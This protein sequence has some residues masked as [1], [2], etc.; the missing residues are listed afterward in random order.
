[1]H[2]N[3]RNPCLFDNVMLTRELILVILSF[4]IISMSALS[5]RR[6]AVIGGGPAGLVTTKQLIDAGIRPKLFTKTIGGMWNKQA[7]PFWPSMKT[8]L[9]KYTCQFSDQSWQK[10]APIFP[11]QADLDSYLNTYAERTLHRANVVLNC[12]ITAVNREL[13]GEY[14]LT[15]QDCSSNAI[16]CE[17]FD[18]VIITTG[19]FCKPILQPVD[20]F[21]GRVIHSSEYRNPEDFAGRNVVVAGSSFSSSEIA[22]DVATV[23]SSVRNVVPRPS[24]M[25]PRFLPVSTDKPNTPFL[26][27]DLLFYQLNPKKDTIEARREVLIKHDADRVKSDTY[28]KCLQ[29]SVA[30]DVMKQVNTTYTTRCSAYF[31]FY[32]KSVLLFASQR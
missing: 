5:I 26:P 18:D 22:A 28:M 14:K 17:T 24:W 6:V 1:M 7:N 21:K 15:W 10:D 19:F 12:N 16:T 8:N 23:A 30:N 29:G 27:L 2:W 4:S 13:N 25:L 3:N 11:N 32:G 9:S 20:G 31:L